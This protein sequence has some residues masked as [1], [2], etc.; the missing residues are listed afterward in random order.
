MKPTNNINGEPAPVK[1]RFIKENA[2]AMA[3]VLN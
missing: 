1:G 3:E 2:E